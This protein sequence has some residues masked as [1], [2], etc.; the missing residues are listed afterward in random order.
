MVFSSAGSLDIQFHFLITF[1][2]VMAAPFCV[3]HFVICAKAPYTDR[4]RTRRTAKIEPFIVRRRGRFRG[5]G[6]NAVLG[7]TVDGYK[8]MCVK[9]KISLKL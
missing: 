5:C 3:L 1:P 7:G 9:D 8:K 2:R 4:Y 6:E